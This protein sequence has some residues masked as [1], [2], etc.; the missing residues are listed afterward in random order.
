M[1]SFE[2]D[3]NTGA[4]PRIL[5]RLVQTNLQ[6]EPGY[7]TDSFCSSAAEHLR[8]VF[9]CPEGS[10][11]FLTGGTQ[12][13]AIVIDS[14]LRSYEG[15]IAAETGH[16]SWHEAG[17]IEF[18]RHKVLPLPAYDGKLSATELRTALAQFRTNGNREHMTFP[19][20]VYITYPTE[21]GTLYTRTE[22]EAL[23]TV[24]REYDLPLFLDG[25]RLGY[26][27][28]SRASDITPADI[29]ALTDVF[30]VGGTKLG[31]L[32]GEAVIFPR[33]N[34]PPHFTTFVKQHGGLLAKGRLLGLQFDVLFEDGLYFDISRHAIEMAEALKAAFHEKNY[35]F[36]KET[37]TNQQF[38]L[39]ENSQYERL[40]K[41]VAFGYWDAYDETHTI[42]RF[43]TGWSTQ[44][45]HVRALRAAL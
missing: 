18:T 3:Y 2:S 24:C 12:T 7:G 43:V 4:H 1:V 15:V 13:N 28:M 31:A 36:W 33:G 38:I 41:S 8:R 42:A 39:L 35:T 16:I 34:M 26:G 27:L 45:E 10:V 14:L 5:E 19:G 32:C 22:L 6:P 44:P 25:A 9:H 29:A 40:S 11:F 30:Y 37:P 20:M 23:H 17:A 21:L